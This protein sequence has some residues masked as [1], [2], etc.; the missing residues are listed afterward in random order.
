MFSYYGSKSKIVHLYPPP[1]FPTIVEPFAGSARYALRYADR[2]VILN[3]LDPTI[4]G[5]WQYLIHEATPE[6]IAQLPELKVGE[7]LDSIPWLTDEERD[8]MGFS[9]QFGVYTPRITV[10]EEGG[11][12]KEIAAMKRRILERLG[13]DPTNY[14]TMAEKDLL[15]MAVGEGRQ[16]P[17]MTMTARAARSTLPV[18]H[19]KY[20]SSPAGIIALKPKL[21]RIV[22]S[23]KHWRIL[24]KTY[25]ELPDIE[26]TWFIDPPYCGPAGRYYKYNKIDYEDLADWCRTR[27][28]QVIVCEGAG[29]EWLPFRPLGTTAN[30]SKRSLSV[31]KWW[32]NYRRASLWEKV[33]GSKD[34]VPETNDA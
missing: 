6:R 27:K 16:Q 3:D 18:D 29:A 15:G 20:R 25:Q 4:A 21:V 13:G 7:R 32:S 12:R 10:S 30:G 17:Q 24:S 22:P 31:E 28:G 26:A 19:P 14:L 8:L 11:K 23:I 1:M 2:K 34:W 5:I 33:A 9:V